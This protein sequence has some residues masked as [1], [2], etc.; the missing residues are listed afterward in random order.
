MIIQ[1]HPSIQVQINPMESGNHLRARMKINF[2]LL[3]LFLFGTVTSF[4]QTED[5]SVQ[6]KS[7]T[8]AGD[9]PYSQKISIY[10]SISLDLE[11]EVGEKMRSWPQ[12]SEDILAWEEFDNIGPAKSSNFLEVKPTTA[13]KLG[14]TGGSVTSTANLSVSSDTI[15]ITN[16]VDTYTI[17]SNDGVS[18]SEAV[19]LAAADVT[20]T[21]TLVFS[22]AF[23]NQTVNL[24]PV[25]LTENLLLNLDIPTGT[26]LI[27]GTLTISDGKILE[28]FNGSGDTF[29]LGVILDGPGSIK[30]AGS[31]TLLLTGSNSYAGGTVILG[32]ILYGGTTT[33]SPDP[34]TRTR[35]FL[36]TGTVTI[37]SSGTLQVDRVTL[38]NP[39]VLNG[40]SLKATNGGFPAVWNGSI[41]LQADSFFETTQ[42]LFLRGQISGSGKLIYIG[43]STSSRLTLTNSATHTG[44]TDVRNGILVIGHSGTVETIPLNGTT[45]ELLTAISTSSTATVRFNRSNA[46]TYP[47][48][49][50]GQGKVQIQNGG[51]I[52]LTGAHSYTGTTEI[53]SGK[54]L[55]DN[56]SITSATS[57]VPSGTNPVTL[58]GAGTITGNVTTS[59]VA[60]R[61]GFIAPGGP[62]GT[63]TINGNL[64]MASGST[65]SIDINGATVGIT[66]D[67]VI[68]NGIVNVTGANLLLSPNNIDGGTSFIILSNDQS[69]AITGT[70]NGIV[71]G[72]RYASTG[73]GAL[74]FAS[75]T[76]NG[77]G[78]DFVF[79]KNSVPSSKP[80]TDGSI[81]VDPLA[82]QIY[83][84]SSLTPTLVIKDGNTTLIL[85]TD[86]TVTYSSNTDVGTATVT[87]T[88][89][90]NYTSTKTQT[91]VIVAKAA[92]TLTL[93]AIAN[94]T[95]TGAALTP[96]AVV[97][98]GSTTLVAGIDYTVSYNSNTNVGTATVT[99]TGIG[100]YSGTK[101]QTFV[102]VA[103]AAST[104]TL[105]AIANQ[106]YTGSTITPTVVV[107]DGS[108]TLV[109]GTDYTV[110]YSSNTNVGTATVTI[111]GIGN[112]TGTKTQTFVIVAKAASTLT[113]D[114]LANQT[115]TGSGITP[116][117]VVKDG[118][119]TLL[120]GTEY[121][122]TYSSNTD[123]GTAT[124]TITGIGNYTGTKTQTFVIVAKA[125]SILTL[126][127][128]AN[129]TYTGSII[130][131]TVVVKDGSTTL[132]AG[133]DYTVTYSSNTNVGTAMV[134][135]RG[136][137]NYTDTKTQTF[138][139]VAKAA[140][141]LDLDAIAN[142][143]YTGSTITPTVVVKDG[144]TT[145]VS[146]TDYTV[147]YSSNTNVGTATVTITGIGNYKGTKTQ[148]FVIVAKAAS[149][150]ALDA[151]A[152]QTYT[153]S[154]ITPTVVVKDGSTTLAAGTDYTVSYSSNTNVG[155]A[156]VTITGIGN[157]TGT[158]TQTFVIVAKAASTLTVELIASLEYTGT[159]LTPDVVVKDGSATL[160]L[161]TDYTVEYRN[162]ENAGSA[163]VTIT[164][165]GNY[166][167]SRTASFAISPKALTIRVDNKSKIYGD[168]NPIFSLTYNGLVVGDTEIDQLPTVS[169]TATA[170]SSVGNYRITLSGGVDANYAITL[171][172]G[173]L[174]IQPASLLVTS[175]PQ[176]KI[177]GKADP[178]FKFTVLG[179]KGLDTEEIFTG[180]LQRNSGEDPGLYSI[181]QGTLSPGPNYELTFVGSTFEILIARALVVNKLA[182]VETEWSK[183]PVLPSLVDLGT[184]DGQYFSVGVDWDRSKVNLLARGRYAISGKLILPRGIENP[185]GV[186]TQIEVVVLPKAKP[187]DITLANASF[188]GSAN[189]FFIPV[190]AFLVNDPVDK[191]HTVSLLGNGYDNSYFEIKDN[192]LFWSSKDP[193]AGKTTFSLVV[194]VTDRDGNTLDKFFEI[195]RSRLAFA[196][197]AIP[198][199][200]TPN[201]DG[202]NESWRIADLRFYSNVRIQVFNQVGE[203]MF[204]TEIPDQGWDGT[205]KG[206]VLPIGSYLWII[207]IGETGEI[208]R[209]ILSL[210]RK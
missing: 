196:D 46:F 124:V 131:P 78:N 6:G 23:T 97:K 109:A 107:K 134:T 7:R 100:N 106:T 179:L 86:Y 45:G 56:G 11:S 112:Y 114:A 67:Q 71:E 193:R 34:D 58:G 203:S 103:K 77:A 170:N 181:G 135:I 38:A 137:G 120:E 10:L 188:E 39:I 33:T 125:A 175:L 61:S 173:M 128:I 55:L 164:G 36:G 32:G 53:N 91:F 207:S 140:S 96:V 200:F 142:Q 42:N 3:F 5:F 184:T 29:T 79:A 89:I 21:Q 174:S 121:T 30:K 41:T 119:T 18:F 182:A 145:L 144:S 16:I 111:T 150:L 146:G 57:L 84:G 143:T 95:Y 83:T 94:Q 118:S 138:V 116:T 155:T 43:T 25:T 204:Y 130:T 122:V 151:I 35:P 81:T 1:N 163:S 101:T 2:H 159:R 198:S 68:V 13:P 169:T 108:T 210:V 104:L 27:G 62:I 132:V 72:A 172:E 123:V 85:G 156:T 129:Q 154:G 161:N 15:S 47:G 185:D 98:D 148:T 157:Y 17:D 177:Y 102:I 93:D 153:G 176:N 59:I 49:I 149:T 199:A 65:L 37:N 74:L 73:N 12:R 105:D 52:T 22:A 64:A 126:D 133:T 206:K 187:L 75:Y 26:K 9:L 139:I 24:L 178:N 191:I 76:S 190:G 209:G 205:L 168:S 8:P 158:K 189:N 165:V 69:D 110:T 136:I 20:G 80:I 50:S 31:G 99:I 197:L 117:V 167:G 54:L 201:G 194:R 92:S 166:G 113:L 88:G 19:A 208:R 60:G 90:G 70:F 141:T 28:F 63:L 186:G 82:N 87:I 180:S 183:N 202:I 147:T 160:M 44:G 40:G 51:T 192:F 162:N 171:E 195:K 48:I 66:Y 152:N 127:A 4:G 115:Y 14:Y